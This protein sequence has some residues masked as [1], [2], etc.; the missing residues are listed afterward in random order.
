MLEIDL[1]VWF[2]RCFC[3]DVQVFSHCSYICIR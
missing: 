3:A 2:L 1:I